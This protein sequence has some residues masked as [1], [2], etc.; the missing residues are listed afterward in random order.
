ME[1]SKNIPCQFWK[2]T[3][4]LQTHINKWIQISTRMADIRSPKFLQSKTDWWESIKYNIGQIRPR[5]KLHLYLLSMIH[6]EL[7][8]MCSRNI[9]EIHVCGLTA[10]YPE[11][12]VSPGAPASSFPPPP[13][14]R[15]S[16]TDDNI[17]VTPS[18]H[19]SEQLKTLFVNAKEC[20]WYN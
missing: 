6:E 7:Y 19:I 1:L 4:N 12:A 8:P 15:C 11:V 13:S 5:P 16:A 10:L 9:A 20:W 2:Y 18:A 17:T 14:A 3:I